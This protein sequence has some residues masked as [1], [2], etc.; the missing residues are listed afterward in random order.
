V[1]CQLLEQRTVEWRETLRMGI[2]ACRALEAAHA[3]GV[4]HRDIK[5][6]NLFVTQS[7][8]LKLLDFGIAVGRG[9]P[10]ADGRSGVTGTPE[11]MSPEQATGGDADERSDLYSLGVVLYEMLTG[12]LPHQAQNTATLLELKQRCAVMPPS[13]CVPR[14]RLPKAVDTA[15]LKALSR[16]PADRYASAR[17]M[18]E[19]LSWAALAAARRRS[20]RRAMGFAALTAVMFGLASG[21]VIAAKNPVIRARADETTRPW[22][23]KLNK[24]S[25]RLEARRSHLLAAHTEPPAPK[26]D[27]VASQP[28]HE[29]SDAVPTPEA[30]TD[31]SPLSSLPSDADLSGNVDGADMPEAQLDDSPDDTLAPENKLARAIELGQGERKIEGL[32]MLRRLGKRYPA[33]GRVM[34]AWAAAA[35][36]LGGWGEALK[37]ARHWAGDQDGPEANVELARLQRATGR[38]AE[39]R[40]TLTRILEHH[41]DYEPAQRLL[42]EY[43]PHGRVAAAP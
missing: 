3:A 33:D 1:D 10:D 20:R 34:K 15:I 43:S 2:Q 42:D 11:Y 28:N 19:A 25:E 32:N 23:E 36:S 18:L 13:R 5:P 26:H 37:V 40:K 17:E 12:Q 38:G 4:V 41:P 27:P 7:G 39:A 14:L 6:S 24:L 9:T 8:T 21:T 16:V 22:L 29:R 30:A 31:T 35:V